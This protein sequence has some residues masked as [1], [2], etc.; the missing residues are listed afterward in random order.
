LS[1][2]ILALLQESATGAD[3]MFPSL[4][5]IIA[6]SADLLSFF[7]PL[8]AHYNNPTINPHGGNPAL[9]WTVLALAG[10]GV[11][12]GNF[13]FWILDF[14]TLKTGENPKSKTSPERSERIQNPK[15]VGDRPLF[16]LVAAVVFAV[17]A[18]GPHLLVGGRD[19]G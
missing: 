17:L 7:L 8:P 2:L 13:G 12:A 6:N 11:G 16:W 10:I 5:T 19:T 3:Y 15:L 1:P 14:G 4:E 18:L 9:G